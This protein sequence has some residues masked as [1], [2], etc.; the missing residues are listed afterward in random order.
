MN[1]NCWG[2]EKAYQ[3]RFYRERYIG[4]DLGNPRYDRYAELF[5]ARGY[6]VEHPDQI[7]DVV[8]AAL[9]GATP[10]VIEIPVDPDELGEP[11]TQPRR[12]G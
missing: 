11:P 12:E 2:M 10:A 8:R 6:Y 9:R 3:R 4:A 5:G 7:G 1:N